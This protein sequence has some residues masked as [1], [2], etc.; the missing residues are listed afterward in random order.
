[1]HLW[2]HDE[3]RA[4]KYMRII[5][6]ESSGS[7]SLVRDGQGRQTVASQEHREVGFP[8]GEQCSADITVVLLSPEQA[9]SMM[10]SKEFCDDC[11]FSKEA[12]LRMGVEGLF[13]PQ[14]CDLVEICGHKT[15]STLKEAG[16]TL[17]QFPW[18]HFCSVWS[19]FSFG[20]Q[21]NSQKSNL[22]YIACLLL[23]TRLA[24]Q[25]QKQ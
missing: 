10:V 8:V 9:S 6:R 19:E 13:F 25:L 1:M 20:I 14:V 23:P 5:K 4:W 2:A 17:Q 22:G 18:D 16:Y 21:K 15:E 12:I 7:Y 11:H 24:P 3:Q